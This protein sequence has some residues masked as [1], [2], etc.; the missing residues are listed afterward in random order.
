[1]F[2]NYSFKYLIFFQKKQK[3]LKILKEIKPLNNIKKNT[4][5]SFIIIQNKI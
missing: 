1:M 5:N 4:Y 3:E 2:F